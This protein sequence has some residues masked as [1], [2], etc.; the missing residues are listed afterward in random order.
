M[1]EITYH[2]WVRLYDAERYLKAGWY[3]EWGLA[4][5]LHNYHGVHMRWLCD[6]EV[7]SWTQDGK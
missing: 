2:R 7:P 5:T 6:C 3:P 4:D 1:S